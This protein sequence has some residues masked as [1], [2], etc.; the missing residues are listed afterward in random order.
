MAELSP[1]SC[2]PGRGL[3]AH[4]CREALSRAS[5]G[6]AG[7]SA[8]ARASDA[9]EDALQVLQLQ[10]GF[11]VDSQSHQKEDLRW[12]KAALRTLH[13]VDWLELKRKL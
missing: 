9:D 2:P 3:S 7:A 6:V 4:L 5:R 12:W 13:G 11:E 10:L 1:V 8:F